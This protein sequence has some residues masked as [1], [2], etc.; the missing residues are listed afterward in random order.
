MKLIMQLLIVT[1][2]AVTF[3]HCGT[4][5]LSDPKSISLD[6]AVAKSEGVIP[7]FYLEKV[8]WREEAYSLG[9]THPKTALKALQEMSIDF[10]QCY[11]RH[12]PLVEL[13]TSQ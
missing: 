2:L 1:L 5:P 12:T 6:A 4:K 9:N 8:E 3:S 10:G 13:L 11:S 7:S